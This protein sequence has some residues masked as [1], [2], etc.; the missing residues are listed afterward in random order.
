MM[1]TLL[2]GGLSAV[3]IP[4]DSLKEAGLSQVFLAFNLPA[5]DPSDFPARVADEIVRFVQ[6]PPGS[7]GERVRTPGEKTLALRAE[8]L[9]LG[10]PV[11]PKIWRDVQTLA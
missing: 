9:R 11:D 10:V 8:N 2:S 3:Q 7:A 1:A 6:L 5:L 4:R